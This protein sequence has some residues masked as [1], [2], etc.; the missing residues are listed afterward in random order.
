MGRPVKSRRVTEAGKF[1][2]FA[3]RFDYLGHVIQPGNWAIP[4]KATNAIRGL[5]NPMYV[6][7][8]NSFDQCIV[9]RRLVP[10]F[11]RIV[12]PSTVNWKR[13]TFPI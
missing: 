10:N 11:T 6:T 1:I 13:P 8:L 9:F 5:Q 3:N 7:E 12:A 4:M 2:F